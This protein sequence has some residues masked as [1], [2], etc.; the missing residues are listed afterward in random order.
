MIEHHFE[1]IEAHLDMELLE[2]ALPM[3]FAIFYGMGWQ[4]QPQFQ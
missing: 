3:V 4:L 1:E 2:R